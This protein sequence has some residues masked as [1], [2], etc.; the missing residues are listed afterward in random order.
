MTDAR[1]A[2]S[3]LDDGGWKFSGLAVNEAIQRLCKKWG[4]EVVLGH[5]RDWVA[6]MEKQIE[7][8]E[9]HGMKERT[10]AD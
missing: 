3:V 1:S 10:D 2:E 8:M 5:L 7:T 6:Y 4:T 9:R